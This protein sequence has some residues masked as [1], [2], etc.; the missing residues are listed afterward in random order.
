MAEISA[1]RSEAISDTGPGSQDQQSPARPAKPAAV[2]KS[3]PPKLP[4]LGVPDD[5]E[6]PKLDEM[7]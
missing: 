4:E 7:A 3:E 1:P 6:K 2:A 5:D